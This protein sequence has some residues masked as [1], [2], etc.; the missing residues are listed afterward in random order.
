MLPSGTPWAVVRELGPA[1]A[2]PWGCKVLDREGVPR[3]DAA[4]E[5][6]WRIWTNV[7]GAIRETLECADIQRLGFGVLGE[8]LQVG[9]HL[10]ALPAGKDVEMD[11]DW[12]AH[13]DP[14][15]GEPGEVVIDN[16][17]DAGEQ[18]E[19]EL[20]EIE[21]SDIETI[22]ARGKQKPPPEGR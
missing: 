21:P 5:K 6:G 15:Q 18:E 3:F 2:E 12:E 14:D 19:G 16:P 11:V 22:V 17:N 7:E 20:E 10:A 8:A 13:D 4:A 9:V 1:V